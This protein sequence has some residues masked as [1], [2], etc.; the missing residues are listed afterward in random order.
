MITRTDHVMQLT[1]TPRHPHKCTHTYIQTHMWRDRGVRVCGGSQNAVTSC[2]VRG[3][4]AY[5]LDR[6]ESA[7]QYKWIG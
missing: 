4:Y 2:G 5:D 6:K 1:H 3:T 7:V